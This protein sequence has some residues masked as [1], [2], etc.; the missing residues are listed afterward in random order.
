[1]LKTPPRDQLRVIA[2]YDRYARVKAIS[3]ALSLIF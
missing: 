1:M 2:I 3:G